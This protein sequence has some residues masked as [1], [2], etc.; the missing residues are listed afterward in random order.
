[1][2]RDAGRDWSGSAFLSPEQGKVARC[3]YH[4]M[5]VCIQ[6]GF[7][8]LTF[9]FPR[10]YDPLMQHLSP[11]LLATAHG[12]LR[13]SRG[14]HVHVKRSWVLDNV[15]SAVHRVFR[16]SLCCTGIYN[17]FFVP[18]VPCLR[19]NLGGADQLLQ[20]FCPSTLIV[21]F[22]SLI[23]SLSPRSVSLCIRNL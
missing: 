6:K 19:V 15:H 13:P 20:H 14:S 21:L 12:C 4:E 17:G 10:G 11:F 3:V 1:M 9:S 16:R 18:N 23:V 7:H 22:P 8:I 5:D 2:V